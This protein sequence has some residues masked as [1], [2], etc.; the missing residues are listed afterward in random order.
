MSTQMFGWGTHPVEPLHR[1]PAVDI[2]RG[3][4]VIGVLFVH[5][6]FYGAPAYHTGLMASTHSLPGLAVLA[7]QFFAQGKFDALFALLF[8]A[9]IAMQLS[10]Y[11]TV[12]SGLPRA[13]IARRLIVLAVIGVLHMTLLWYGD[14][15]FYYGI[16][17]ILLLP[18][19]RLPA[20]ALLPFAVFCLMFPAIFGLVKI[21]YHFPTPQAARS[22]AAGPRQ[23]DRSGQAAQLAAQ[24]AAQQ[25]KRTYSAG[26]FAEV[27]EQ[28]WH[29]VM[30]RVVPTVISLPH[31]FGMFIIGMYVGRRRIVTGM[32]AHLAW[33]RRVFW[34]SLAVGLI[35]NMIS[36]GLRLVARP[37]VMPPWILV[38]AQTTFYLSGP[39]LA[40]AY[41]SGIALLVTRGGGL[42]RS[43]F[44]LG[45]AGRMALTNGLLQ[46][47][48]CTTLF[49]G[50]GFG[51]YGKLDPLAMVGL[52]ALIVAAEVLLSRAWLK[53]F[54]FGPVEWLWR[55]A[56]FGRSPEMKRSATASA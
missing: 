17:G 56:T 30:I 33:I 4:A 34:W 14:L 29:D 25:S 35:V 37:Q 23:S 40:C 6:Q 21:R 5:V 43:L 53:Q 38:P 46:S 15:L 10:D 11:E 44:V 32:C 27:A 24:Q 12:S 31:L 20:K 16:L 42:A 26:S 3:L 48:V 8:G 7:V 13:I 47:I 54:P 28:R 50:Y 45:P 1:I 19:W 41:A 9:G 2:A 49:Y 22:A 52:A 18:L 51:L 36:V 55:F 39:I